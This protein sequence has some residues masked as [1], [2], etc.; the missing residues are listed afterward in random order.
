MHGIGELAVSGTL[1]SL[2]WQTVHLVRV[3][4][5]YRLRCKELELGRRP[6]GLPVRQPAPA[7]KARRVPQARG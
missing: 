6:L 1:T 2:S 5:T 3:V 7:A 4:L